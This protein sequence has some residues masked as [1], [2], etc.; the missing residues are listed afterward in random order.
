MRFVTAAVAI[1]VAL[2]NTPQQPPVQVIRAKAMVDVEAGALVSDVTLVIRGDRIQEVGPTGKVTVP[3]GASVINLQ[4]L[5]LLP[6]L[7]DT[8]VHLT[9]AGQPED[10]A[11]ATLAAGFTTVQD[12]GALAYANLTLRDTIA[13]GRVQGPR[14]VA[15]G[16]WLG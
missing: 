1:L 10:N 3:P 6:G 8:H 4:K 12:L 9:L 2:S 7:I 11:K 16:P 14:V 15:S 13:A 5:T